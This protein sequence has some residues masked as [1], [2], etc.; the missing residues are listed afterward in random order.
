MERYTKD[1]LNYIKE[2]KDIDMSEQ[3][4]LFMKYVPKSSKILDAG[5]GSGRDI[6]FFKQY[7]DVTGIDLSGEFVSYVKENIHP[8][9]YQMDILNLEFDEKFDAIWA[10]ASLVHFDLKDLVLSFNQFHKAL[11]QQGILYVSLKKKSSFYLHGQ[12][13]ITI[14]NLMG[15]L[16]NDFMLIESRTSLS[17]Y[18]DQK[19]ESF[20]F[21]AI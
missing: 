21:K 17:N 11:N 6:S 7:Y 2:T 12:E 20:I 9:V 15:N 8:N 16:S 18:R 13:K 3:Y 5:F 10:C 14:V 4:K 19:W 1:Y